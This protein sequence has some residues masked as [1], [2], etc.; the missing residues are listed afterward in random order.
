MQIKMNNFRKG[1][2]WNLI[3]LLFIGLSFS[4]YNYQS[5]KDRDIVV[6]LNKMNFE[7]MSIQGMIEM[8]DLFKE[9]MP[10]VPEKFWRDFMAEVDAEYLMELTVPIYSK[11]LT[12]NDIIDLI[13]FYDSPIGRKYINVLPYITTESM[14]AGE[15][16]GEE[17][18]SKLLLNIEEYTK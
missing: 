10:E 5:Q 6:L 12:H 3:Y 16:W 8:I 4:N 9:T 17:I 13:R 18:A 7:E 15:K 1:W 14:I 11:Y 2:K